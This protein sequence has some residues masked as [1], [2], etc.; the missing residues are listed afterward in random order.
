MKRD[1]PWFVALVSLIGA[2][3]VAAV[4]AWRAAS[5]PTVG[6]NA[7]AVWLGLALLLVVGGL[8]VADEVHQRRR[9]RR[10]RRRAVKGGGR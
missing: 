2:A 4:L 8:F 10:A 5:S 7:Y 6:G 1:A 9:E 3:F